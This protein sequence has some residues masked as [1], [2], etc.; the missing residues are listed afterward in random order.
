VRIALDATYSVDPT[1]T[2]IAVYSRELLHGLAAAHPKEEFLHCYRPKQF[3]RALSP[4]FRNV[5]RRVLLPPLPTFRAD[6]F[7]ALNQR[8][9]WRPARKVLSTFHDLFV[10]TKQYSSEE[11]RERFIGQARRA[12]AN[13]DLII[14]VSEFTANQVE[15]LLAV[16]RLRIRVVP[17]GINSIQEESRQPRG[18]NVLFVGA[19]QVRK[20]IMRLVQAFEQLP[21][22]WTLTL[23]GATT[24]YGASEILTQV[25]NS[26]AANRIEVT[27]YVTTESLHRL[28]GR[29]SIFAFPSLDEGF[30][31]PVLD[32][33]ARGLPVVTSKTSAL[34]EVAGD[35]ALLVDPYRTE[36]IAAAL[37]RLVSEPAER[38]RLAAMSRS[39]AKLFSWEASVEKTYAIYREV[40]G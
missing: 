40:L 3:R 29:A 13:S 27:G 31:M 6:L 21:Q 14:A 9:D 1:P 35:A 2:G 23:A 4:D 38:E 5:R 25:K 28:Y 15:H 18:K 36:D 33:M 17:H 12:A 24:G 7:H 19:L 34:P 11:F 37:L 32:A 8:V 22:D 26:T 20:N 16:P 10:I 30:G 39:R